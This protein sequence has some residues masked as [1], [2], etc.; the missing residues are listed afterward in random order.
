[1]EIARPTCQPAHIPTSEGPE[2]TR[3][4]LPAWEVRQQRP[5]VILPAREARHEQ[6]GG[7]ETDE[8]TPVLS[9]LKENPDKTYQKY[10]S[11][12]TYLQTKN[13]WKNMSMREHNPAQMKVKDL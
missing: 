2:K 3:I 6:P 7:E 1:M 13:G 12:S 5:R 4:N 8:K 9:Y 10:K 11:M